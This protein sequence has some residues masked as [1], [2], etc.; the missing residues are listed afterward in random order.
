MPIK[1]VE[2][3]QGVCMRESS[4]CSVLGLGCT[5]FKALTAPLG[6]MSQMASNAL[7]PRQWDPPQKDKQPFH[8]QLVASVLW[9]RLRLH[10]LCMKGDWGDLE[11]PPSVVQLLPHLR[12]R[13]RQAA[14]QR[15][16]R[17]M[18]LALSNVEGDEDLKIFKALGICSVPG[19][20]KDAPA[21]PATHTGS[22]GST[23]PKITQPNN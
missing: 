23:F 4:A 18:A 13:S 20:A 9:K 7:F 15:F 10:D 5:L 1:N 6:T 3:I 14:K 16:P 19:S 11:Q 17:D 12:Q 22:N 21:C 8:L 2:N